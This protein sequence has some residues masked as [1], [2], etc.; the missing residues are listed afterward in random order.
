MCI[1]DRKIV[2]LK[3]K[4]VR[5]LPQL[6]GV[7]LIFISSL[8][9]RGLD[10]L[11]E[12]ILDVHQVWNKRLPTAAL[13]RWMAGVLEHHPPPA[14]QGKRIKLRYI[15]QVKTRPPAFIVMCSFPDSLPE[16]YSRYLVNNLR[17]QFDMP[18]IPIRLF[19]RSQN[20]D[21]PFKNRKRKSASKLRKHLK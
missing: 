17:E 7:P 12:A 3:E 16:S 4:C 1:R 6:R 20:E 10:K 13:N 8:T 5:L 19:F 11:L 15:T 2:D 21:N 9:G 14:R 18:G